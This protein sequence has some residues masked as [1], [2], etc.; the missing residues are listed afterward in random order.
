MATGAA[1]SRRGNDSQNY[2]MEP[3]KEVGE[4]EW[5]GEQ[6]KQEAEKAPQNPDLQAVWPATAKRLWPQ[7]EP[8]RAL[9]CSL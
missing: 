5:G 3:K 1:G 8:G 4:R 7:P 9:L 6:V 2:S